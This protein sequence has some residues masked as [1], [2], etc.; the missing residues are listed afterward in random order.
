MN[1][2]TSFWMILGFS[3][4]LLFQACQ[5]EPIFI[6]E[7]GTGDD[8][9]IYNNEPPCAEGVI[10]FQ[11]QVLPL[12]ISN[13]AYSGCHDAATAEEGIVLDSYQNIRREVK[14]GK[15]NDSELYESITDSGDEIMPPP[16]NAPLSSSDIQLIK[17]WINQGAE[18]T[19]C[20]L[21]CDPEL[22]AFGSNIAPLVRTHCQGCH[23]NA[24]QQGN[25]NLEGYDNIKTYIEDGSFLGSIKHEAG[26]AVMPPSGNPLSDCQISQIEKWIS[27]GA[28]NN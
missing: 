27:E 2:K 11:A 23:S 4:S 6:G 14:P 22:S 25:V 10:S 9:P 21:P 3:L 13:C 16:P 12:I 18:N 1:N 20:G 7:E 24:S 17:S 26:Y 28:T 19:I 5:S 15:P 8:P